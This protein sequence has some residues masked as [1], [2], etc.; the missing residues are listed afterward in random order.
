VTGRGLAVHGG[1]AL[2]GLAVA[3]GTWQRDPARAE[4]EVIVVDASKGELSNVHFEDDN[5]SVDVARGNGSGESGVWLK[6][7]DKTPVPSPKPAAAKDAP[8]ESTPPAPPAKPRPLRLLRGDEPAEKLLTA[9]APFRSP[10]AFGVLDAKKAKELGLED[11][12]KKLVNPA[13]GQT[14]SVVIGQPAQSSGENYLRD[15]ADG[16][17]YLMP[18]Q[19]LTDL[20]GALFRLVDRKLHTFKISEANRVVITGGGKSREFVIKNNQDVNGY[21]LAAAATPDK[22]DEMA[23]NWHDKIWRT[24]PT[25]L[26]GKDEKPV[27]GQPKV[28]AR[29]E[30]FDGQKSIGWLEIGK[31]DVPPNAEP[32]PAVNPHAPAPVNNGLELYGRTEHTAGWVRLNNDPSTLTEAEKVAGS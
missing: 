29:V 24:F 3:Y 6:V 8:K 20:Q 9:F 14:R 11:A 4:G 19:L 18:R 13:R 32:P 16:R 7:Q 15:S 23:R 30:Y 12:K 25:E 5:T 17:T 26:L 31:V 10:R 21:K 2:V 22:P 28:S 1:L 27:H